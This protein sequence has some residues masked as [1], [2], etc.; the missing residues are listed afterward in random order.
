MYSIHNEG[1][2]VVAEKFIRTLKT[3]IYKYM[4]SVSKNVYIDQLDDIV[5]EYNNAYH[6]TIK[7]KPVDVKDNTYIDFK[8]EVNDKDPK[9][10][11]GD[12]VRISKYK[13]IFAKG[14]TPNWS[15]EVFEIKK[16]KNT[17]P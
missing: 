16:V 15:E 13:N 14:H 17:V 6:R 7:M 9:F 5:N 10:K 1:K 2:S 12:N 4:T 8:K 3:K 11:V